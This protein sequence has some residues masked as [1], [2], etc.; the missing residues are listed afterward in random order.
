MK[1][2]SLFP[3][4]FS[5][6]AGRP[7]GFTVVEVVLIV[8]VLAILAGIAVVSYQKIIGDAEDNEAI[9]NL[10]AIRQAEFAERA[11]SGTFVN[12]S[13]TEDVT[14]QLDILKLQDKIFR[15][16]VVN[17]T[18]DDFVALAERIMQ[19]PAGKK[20]A[21]ISLSADGTLSKST[22]YYG[23][24]Y[25]GG[26]GSYSGA[27][28]GG[29]G[30][31]GSGSCA[32]CGS[33]GAGDAG[34][35]GEGGGGGCPGCGGGSGALPGGGSTTPT[36]T[37]VDW[38][39]PLACGNNGYI[40][41]G[42]GFS[43][44]FAADY[45]RISRAASPSGPFSVVIDGWPAWYTNYVDTVP[46]GTTYYYQIEAFSS[47]GASVT[48]PTILSATASAT[49]AYA[50]A[51]QAG[52]NVLAAST[53]G[54][55]ISDMI[56]L[57]N[58]PIGFGSGVPGAA[59]WYEPDFNTITINVSE[60]SKSVNV[61]AALLAHEG[62][63]AWWYHDTT[64]GQPLRAGDPDDPLRLY[65]NSIDQEYHAFT[66]G[67][68]VWNEIKGAETDLNQDGWASVMALSEA[69]AKAVIRLYYPGLSEY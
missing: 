37:Y 27:G 51:A 22:A 54:N 2:R 19:D 4:S 67:A 59:A 45:F 13:S 46:N 50:S 1:H 18:L 20:A 10:G 23:T 8:V 5:L 57:Y 55:T 7:R 30:G 47:S 60:F 44:A 26:G 32:S 66:N 14:V 28:G 12:A 6:R 40:Q 29:G 69:E 42:W 58:A 64:Q 43:S 3:A 52:F 53:A 56:A 48:C 31:G 63:H 36:A 68:N 62:T 15:Y 11:Q 17:A 25:L 35:G 21:V 24:T 65:D 61:H 34:S 41:L 38:G 16:K 33:D 49:G 39:A 9:A